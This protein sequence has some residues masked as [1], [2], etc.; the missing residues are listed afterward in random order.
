MPPTP[1]SR[2]SS[3]SAPAVL[4]LVLALLLAGCGSGDDDAPGTAAGTTTTAARAAG[5]TFPA[6]VTHK[7][8]T[9]TVPE[10]P[11]RIVVAG[12]TEQDTV[13][14][15]GYTPVATTEW[16]GSQPS[17]VWPW[18]Q[19]ALGGAKP[20][21]LKNADGLQFEKIAALRPDLIIGTNAGMKESDYRKLSRLAPTIAAP[22]GSSDYFSPWNEQTE[23]IAAALGMPEQ[24]RQLVQGVKDRYAAAAKAHPEFAGKTA[25]FTQGQIYNGILYAY[26]PGLNTEFLSYLGFR[27]NP[28]LDAL[29]KEIGV[30]VE[31][32]TERLEVA[33]ADVLVAATEKPADVAKLL[34]VPTF[35]RLDAVA[36]DRTIYTDATLAG[37]LYFM[38]PLSLTYALDRLVPQLD[39]ALEG[40]AP[41]RVVDTAARR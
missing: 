40:R 39:A 35:D 1:S 12:L 3:R 36:K 32:S 33:D 6:T 8:G 13:L 21:V 20:T 23:L 27:I 18:A 16:Y 30:Q 2:R 31:I 34:K 5:A 9:V 14:Q 38:T 15:L 10:R 4:L 26:Q 28:K 37:A 25:T 17:A 41:R 24:G 19:K 22:K 7:F 11:T 29:V